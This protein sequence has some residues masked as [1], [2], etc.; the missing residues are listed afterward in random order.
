MQLIS[1][2][3]NWAKSLKRD[4]VAL[5][6]AARD[7]R[8]PWHAKAVAG[9]VAA[10]A[11]SPIDLIP[12]FIPVFGYLDDLFIVPLGIM[13]AIRLVPVEVMNELRTE[14]TGRIERPPSRVGLIF[15]LAVWLVCIIFLALA[16]RKLA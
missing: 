8:V 11:L 13:L 1:K 15:I 6:L 10:Y 4:I 14:A 3:K 12:D 5:W 7:P 16:L 2:A 9:A